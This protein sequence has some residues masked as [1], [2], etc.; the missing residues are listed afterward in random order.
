M[1]SLSGCDT[2]SYPCGKGKTSALKVLKG[3]SMLGLNTVLGEPDATLSDL[4][5]IGTEFSLA[6][7]GQMEKKATRTKKASSN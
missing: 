4:K 6:L 5:D 1:H 2:V 3:S 7:Y